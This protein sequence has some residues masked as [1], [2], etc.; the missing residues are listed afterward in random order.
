MSTGP[1]R[2]SDN[3]WLSLAGTF[4]HRKVLKDQDAAGVVPLHPEPLAAFFPEDPAEVSTLLQA[5]RA[6]KVK[7]VSCGSCSRARAAMEKRLP[8]EGYVAIGLKN[9]S[10]VEEVRPDSLWMSVRA[11][12]P[13]A[14]VRRSAEEHGLQL[15]AL[16][17]AAVGDGTVGGWLSVYGNID[18][19]ILGTLQPAVLSVEAVLPTGNL[20]RSVPVPRAATG[21]DLFAM[22]LGTWG[23]FG[24]I[25]RATL[26][27]Q[28]LT[29]RRI[30]AGFRFSGI[31]RALQVMRLVTGRIWPPRAARLIVWGEAGKKK[32]RLAMGFEGE[33]GLV[34]AACKYFRAEAK[35][36][37]GRMADPDEA[38]SW[39]YADLAQG[40]GCH[41]GVVRWSQVT[42]L[43][44]KLWVRLGK[45]EKLV[46]D[47]PGLTGCR[48]QVVLS[49]NQA[50]RAEEFMALMDPEE[51]TREAVDAA[52]KFLARVRVQLDPDGLVNPHAWPLP[53]PG[54]CP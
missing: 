46:L 28:P 45:V 18:D 6:E 32:V 39:L 53:P 12:T 52:R 11:G 48:L 5:A 17:G 50:G 30:L 34:E 9:L 51:S 40:R 22:F 44:R 16:E 26:K 1:N 23:G 2:L 43:Q 47:R 14:V 37:G 4:G 35:R 42:G 27:L 38:R 19:A 54:G 36:A 25:T 20:V 21:P 49:E 31:G 3:F 24:V 10:G 29:E 13:L 8:A 41:C 7:V 33:P 15:P